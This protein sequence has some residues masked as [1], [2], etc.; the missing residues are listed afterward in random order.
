MPQ[1]NYT[2]HPNGHFV[3]EREVQIYEEVLR[4]QVI[5]PSY[6]SLPVLSLSTLGAVSKG[7]AAVEPFSFWLFSWMYV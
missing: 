5:V 2:P 1:W 4:P 3:A 6:L 7:L